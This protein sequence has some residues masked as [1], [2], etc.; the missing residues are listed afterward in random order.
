MYLAVTTLF[1]RKV[2]GWG[3][4]K[5]N[6][7]AL[8]YGCKCVFNKKGILIKG[9]SIL[10]NALN[11]KAYISTLITKTNVKSPQL[12]FAL[13]ITNLMCFPHDGLMRRSLPDIWCIL[14][15]LVGSRVVYTL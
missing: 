15:L 3:C 10:R 5:M 13:C 7:G 9:C 14:H 4:L 2:V 11:Y 1:D 8:F 12:M 6:C